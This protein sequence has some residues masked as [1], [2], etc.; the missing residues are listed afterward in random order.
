[1]KSASSR[2]PKSFWI[3]LLILMGLLSLAI[4]AQPV[5]GVNQGDLLQLEQRYQPP[6]LAAPLGRDQNG[7]DVLKQISFGARVT[8]GIA[9]SVVALSALIGLLIGSWAGWSGG[10]VDLLCMRVV[11]MVQAFPGFLL[12]LAIVAV[13]GPSP[14]HL[15]TAMCLTSWTAYTRLVRGEILHLKERDYVTAARALG[16]GSWRLWTRHLWPGL[17]GLLL[18]QVS[19]GLAGAVMTESALSFLGLGASAETPSWGSMLNSGRRYLVEAPHISFFSGLSILL[20]VL[21]LNLIGD[22]ARKHLGYHKQ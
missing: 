7:T 9:V 18:V 1:M 22:A 16:A 21:S 12:A 14:E 13:L 20:L 15:V 4:T 6:S 8:I 11:D 17:L 19:F 3:G 10:W 2:W 5:S